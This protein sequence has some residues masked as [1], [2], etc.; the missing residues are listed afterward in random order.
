MTIAAL[1][2]LADRAALY[3]AL[4][5]DALSTLLDSLGERGWEADLDAGTLTFT[6]TSDAQRRL[7][8]PAQLI[9]TVAPELR[10]LR[11]GWAHPQGAGDAAERLRAHGEEQGVPALTTPEPAFD[12]TATPEDAPTLARTVGGVLA[13]VTGRSPYFVAEAAGGTLAV[14]L[15]DAPLT[16]L[17][18]A[19]AQAALPRLLPELA[20][21]DARTSVWDLARLA[22]WQLTWGDEAFS[23]AT[24]TDAT[25]TAS[26][27]FDERARIVGIENGGG[28]E[29]GVGSSS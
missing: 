28:F 3:T 19:H 26:F 12:E 20:L 15:L 1:T 29:N 24:V 9:A 18:V 7:V 11:W 10:S 16:P 17:T 2:S 14:F 13:E 5:Q 23:T 25:G 27:R 22:G 6:S 8:L 21:A 4:R